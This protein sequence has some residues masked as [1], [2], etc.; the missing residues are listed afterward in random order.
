MKESGVQETKARVSLPPSFTNGCI[1]IMLR[2]IE[3]RCKF[4]QPK[5][6][7]ISEPFIKRIVF[8]GIYLRLS[9]KKNLTIFEIYDSFSL[10]GA[11]I[12]PVMLIE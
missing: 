5:Q 4:V 12:L 9:F 3:Q 11:K 10:G 6:L 1:N 8:F 7:K 2:L